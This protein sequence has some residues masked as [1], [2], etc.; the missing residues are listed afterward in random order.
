LGVPDFEANPG[1]DVT[2][3]FPEVTDAGG[4]FIINFLGDSPFDGKRHEMDQAKKITRKITV[5]P[6]GG[7]VVLFQYF[8]DW[9][10]NGVR[11][12]GGSGS[13][14]VPPTGR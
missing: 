1:S 6:A 9:F 2:F 12:G 3:T 13:G 7:A 4:T 10:E 14:V 11:T 5:H 8:I